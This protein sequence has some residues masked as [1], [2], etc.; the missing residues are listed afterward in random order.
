[1]MFPINCSILSNEIPPNISSLLQQLLF[2]ENE[3]VLSATIHVA[4]AL[5]KPFSLSKHSNR[6]TILDKPITK[7]SHQYQYP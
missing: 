6:S 2:E 3:E 1:M 7:I 4:P 5:N